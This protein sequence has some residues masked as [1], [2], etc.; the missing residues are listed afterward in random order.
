MDKQKYRIII[1][2]VVVVFFYLL[3]TEVGDRWSEMIRSYRE[4]SAKEEGIFNPDDLIQRKTDLVAKKKMLT[5]RIKKS[6]EGFEQSQIGIVRLI[7]IRAKESNVMLRVLAPLETR[8]VGQMI[9]LGFT[10]EILGS[11]HKIGSYCNSLETGPMP[12]KI[13]KIE[14]MSQKPGSPVLSASLQAKAYI[15]PKNVLQ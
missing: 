12:V 15:F 3:F 1:A 8:T 14:A 13:V 11:Y 7:Q 9:E 6:N 10:I 5:A 2:A 4:I